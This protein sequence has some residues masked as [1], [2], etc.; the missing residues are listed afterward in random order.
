MRSQSRACGLVAD[1]ANVLVG[2]TRIVGVRRYYIAPLAV[3]AVLPCSASPLAIHCGYMRERALRFG[4]PEDTP[5]AI[6]HLG[7]ALDAYRDHGE[8]VLL[9]RRTAW[10]A[11]RSQHPVL[12]V[13]AGIGHHHRV[14]EGEH[15]ASDSSSTGFSITAVMYWLMLLLSSVVLLATAERRDVMGKFAIL[16]M[17]LS[18]SIT[19]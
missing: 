3:A 16:Q 6:R 19:F 17:S 4:K 11:S 2:A 13:P 15:S 5:A 8:C 10:R 9:R 18:G 1:S 14:V 12:E 7:G